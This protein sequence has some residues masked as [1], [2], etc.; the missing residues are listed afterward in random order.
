MNMQRWFEMFYG[1]ISPV[2]FDKNEWF[3]IAIFFLSV[4]AAIYLLKKH[5]IMKKSE[6]IFV[7]LF[8]V[9]FSSLGE[10]VLAVKPTDL[11]DTIDR[12]CGEL[13]DIPLQVI[14][15]PT[16][17]YILLHIFVMF[18]LRKLNFILL[19]S[20]ALTLMEWVS[21]HYFSMYK[22]KGWA[23]YY[24]YLFYIFTLAINMYSLGWFN[25]Q[26]NAGMVQL[27]EKH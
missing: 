9:Y 18:K 24:S 3:T 16:T 22:Y 5:P 10:Y 23:I 6:I 27:K 21:E 14:V 2:A 1:P 15:Y 12:N 11:Y 19:G 7:I 17:I 8:N 13:F 25:K 20:M 4:G 26:S